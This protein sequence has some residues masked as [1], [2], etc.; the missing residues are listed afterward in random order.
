MRAPVWL[1]AFPLVLAATKS[2]AGQEESP[3]SPG[4]FVETIDVTVVNVEVYVTDK[5][6][7]RVR[8]L[9]RED[10]RL[11]EDGLQV[12]ITNFYAVEDRRPVPQRPVDEGTEVADV[13]APP[14]LTIDTTLPEDQRLHLVVYVDNANIEPFHRN[15]VFRYVRGFLGAN[16]TAD[17]RAALYT[18]E[19][20]LNLRQ[21]FTANTTE[22]MNAL[23]ETEGLSAY[24]VTREKERD[25][26]LR[27]I[28]RARYRGEI[29]NRLRMHGEQ[30][31]ND[32]QFTLDALDDMI[33]SLAG[34][35]GRKAVLYVSDGLPMRAAEALYGAFADKFNDPTMAT[36]SLSWDISRQLEELARRANAERV[37]FYTVEAAGLRAHS[38]GAADTSLAR[39]FPQ[40]D[41]IR[42][43]NFASTLHTMADETGGIAITGTSN[44]GPA[45]AK[46]GDD[47]DV[48][49]SLGYQ[50][51][52][53]GDGRYHEIKVETVDRSL[54]VRHRTGYRAKTPSR[55]MADRTQGALIY[56]ANANPLGIDVLLE[57][58]TPS[59]GGRWLVPLVIRIPID[60]VVL[61]PEEDRYVGQLEIYLA[62]IDE[63][64]RRAEV[65]SQ[66]WVVDIPADRMQDAH[67]RLYAHEMRLEMRPGPVKISVGVRDQ[68]G[69]RSSFVSRTLLIGPG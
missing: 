59:E 32:L 38:V 55:W 42:R 65:N 31:Y 44:F 17:D 3:R 56:D 7:N 47:L 48:Y 62:S 66:P 33:D 9:T 54:E 37:T 67:G 12:P 34:L 58:A 8:G 64:G 30:I 28:D 53:G 60:N 61:I 50:A 6:G 13:P 41:M 1:L 21:P 26:L 39:S 68:L 2:V 40:F 45:L 16:L 25:A 24:G 49:Y 10:F 15:N 22:L 20:T 19:R 69:S 4:V 36:E 46:I 29:E 27:D 18:Y 14:T 35:P 43:Q 5:D 52:H 57:G 63:R 11:F 23:R 51:A